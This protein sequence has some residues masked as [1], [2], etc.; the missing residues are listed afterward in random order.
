MVMNEV[1]KIAKAHGIKT[2]RMKKADVIKFIQKSEGN[3]ACFATAS[4]GNCDQAECLWREDC[5]LTSVK[6][7]S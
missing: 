2:S 5:L 4:T 7:V 1:R 3:Y 6:A